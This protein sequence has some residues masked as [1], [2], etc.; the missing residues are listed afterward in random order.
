MI[1]LGYIGTDVSRIG[2]LGPELWAKNPS[3]PIIMLP[4]C[5][6]YLQ[7]QVTCLTFRELL[8]TWPL[9]TNRRSEKWRRYRRLDPRFSEQLAGSVSPDC[10][11]RRKT[12]RRPLYVLGVQ[13]PLKC[14]RPRTSLQDHSPTQRT[15]SGACLVISHFE[16]QRFHWSFSRFL[17][18]FHAA[19]LNSV[20]A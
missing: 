1:G 7:W 6:M 15:L 10:K 16:S 2:W 19:L 13:D 12:K 20:L 9:V 11:I 17:L 5:I 8:E 14:C 18:K 4:H 3:E